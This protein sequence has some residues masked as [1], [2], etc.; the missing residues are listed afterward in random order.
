MTESN[1]GNY[2]SQFQH[3]PCREVLVVDLYASCIVTNCLCV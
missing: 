3:A 1:I 2:L